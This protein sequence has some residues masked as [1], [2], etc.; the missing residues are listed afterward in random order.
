[1][2]AALPAGLG[3]ERKSSLMAFAQ[4]IIFG[5]LI[6]QWHVKYPIVYML[7][8]DACAV[9]LRLR[10]A[11]EPEL[12]AAQSSADAPKADRSGGFCGLGSRP[13]L[14]VPGFQI[15]FYWN[16]VSLKRTSSPS[17]SFFLIS[18][19]LGRAAGAQVWGDA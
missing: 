6:G 4:P 17:A 13:V 18:R 16:S 12:K 2:P 10:I 8:I 14:L 7:T 3:G 15:R 19:W 9:N 5:G 1:M 11:V